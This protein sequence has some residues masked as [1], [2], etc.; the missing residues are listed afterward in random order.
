MSGAVVETDANNLV[1]NAIKFN[2]RGRSVRIDYEAR[3]R[4]RRRVSRIHLRTRAI[5]IPAQHLDRLFE[6]FYAWIL[7]RCV[8]R[9]LGGM[10]WG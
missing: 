5:G 10:V 7:S 3:N 6:R 1:E 8:S 9:E 4:C 2:P